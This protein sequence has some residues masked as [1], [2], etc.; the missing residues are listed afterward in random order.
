L[1]CTGQQKQGRQSNTKRFSH[2]GTPSVE[3]YKI[4]LITKE[5]HFIKKDAQNQIL[6]KSAAQNMRI[7]VSPAVEPPA[8]N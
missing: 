2:S 1:R 7:G 5:Y 3:N 4:Q 6:I 8:T